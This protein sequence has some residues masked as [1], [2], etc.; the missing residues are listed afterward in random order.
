MIDAGNGTAGVVAGPLLRDLG[1]ELEELYCEIDGRF[2]NHFPDPTIPGN[3]GDLIDRVKK[4][5][6]DVGIAY[7]GDA[8]RIGVVD[9]SGNI[10]PPQRRS[11][12]FYSLVSPWQ[13]E[14]SIDHP[15]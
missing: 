15:R 12:P 5:R 6:A 4:I 8:D 14:S 3:L 10:S 9:D 2:P 7:D 1:C 13:I 11:P